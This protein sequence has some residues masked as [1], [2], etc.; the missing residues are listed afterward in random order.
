M[1]KKINIKK[2]K[3][4]IHYRIIK[5]WPILI[6]SLKCERGIII[7]TVKFFISNFQKWV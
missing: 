7:V 3:E 2:P 5:F 4:N 6:W 1:V